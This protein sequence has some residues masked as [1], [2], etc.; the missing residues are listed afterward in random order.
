LVLLT[1]RG[2]TAPYVGAI[3]QLYGAGVFEQAHALIMQT[4]RFMGISAP[5]LMMEGCEMLH[6]LWAAYDKVQQFKAKPV[7]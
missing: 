7:L 5:G 6:K 2:D 1:D 3:R 4:D